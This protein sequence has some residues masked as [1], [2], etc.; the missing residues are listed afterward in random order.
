M[1]AVAVDERVV[2]RNLQ[3]VDG[4]LHR[5]HARAENVRRIDLACVDRRDGAG[6]GLFENN[7][8]KR[9]ALFL[10][11]LFGIVQSFDHAVRR[12]D[13]RSG[14]HRP[15]QRPRAR[16]VHAADGRKARR[17]GFLL[18]MQVDAHALS[19]SG[20]SS[21]VKRPSLP[22]R[23]SS[24]RMRLIRSVSTSPPEIKNPRLR[25]AFSSSA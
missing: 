19:P 6:D 16:L 24:S 25:P 13:D 15:H 2:R 4:K 17:A 18:K 20:G 10:R 23:N 14:I 5:L 8:E 7:G 9:F 12:Q 22:P 11:Q 3:R 1:V 21:S